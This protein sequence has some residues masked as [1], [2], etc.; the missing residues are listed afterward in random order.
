MGYRQ[1]KSCRGQHMFDVALKS[2]E[3]VGAIAGPREWNDTREAWLA[4]AARRLGWNYWRTRNVWLKRVELSASEWIHLQAIFDQ[5]KQSA[6]EREET[7]HELE[8][9]ARNAVEARA[10]HSAPS[11]ELRRNASKTRPRSVGP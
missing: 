2:A 4:R 9:L 6:I 7:A 1:H 10:Q 5:F 3:M 8:V 11:G